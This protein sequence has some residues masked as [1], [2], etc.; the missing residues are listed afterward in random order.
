[1]SPFPLFLYRHLQIFQTLVRN[2]FL[3][4]MSSIMQA[5]LSKTEGK[6]YTVA[7][8]T[9]SLGLP[10]APGTFMASSLTHQG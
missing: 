2:V 9:L 8:L 7:T 5:M 1:M 10:V 4:C 6:H 3:F